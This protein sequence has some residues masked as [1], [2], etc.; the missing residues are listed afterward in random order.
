MQDHNI[1]TNEIV[2]NCSV[3]YVEEMNFKGLQKRAKNTTINE[4]TE[5]INKKKN[6]V[7]H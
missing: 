1:M 4:K 6:S 7:N 3:V 5:K 2:R